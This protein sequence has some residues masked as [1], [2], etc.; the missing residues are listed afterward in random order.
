MLA[1][2][3]VTCTQTNDPKHKDCSTHWSY[4]TWKKEQASVHL[5]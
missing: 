3:C 1:N 2:V 4:F 5:G